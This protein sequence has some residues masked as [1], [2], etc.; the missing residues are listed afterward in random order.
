MLSFVEISPVV[1]V[2]VFLPFLFFLPLEKGVAFH[3]Y[4]L[5]SPSPKCKRL[6]EIGPV[7]LEEKIFKY[8]QCFL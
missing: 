2:N 6:V 3:F 1:L 7:V 4:K 8:R 5:A